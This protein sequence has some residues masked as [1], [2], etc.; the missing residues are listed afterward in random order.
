MATAQNQTLPVEEAA[1]GMVAQIGCHHVEATDI[2]DM[3]QAFVR[4]R[5]KLTLVVGRARRLGKP[6]DVA[7]PQ[8]VG[9]AMTHP[10][11]ILFQIFVGV[12]GY[13]SRKIF[14]RQRIAQQMVTPVFRRPTTTDKP[15]QHTMLHLYPFMI[16]AFQLFLPRKENQLRY[17]G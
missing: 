16:V 8:H 10:V 14:I 2:V 1:V 13:A 11:D 7:R 12:E 17:F 5:D 3:V 15:T 6:L 4:H 9:F